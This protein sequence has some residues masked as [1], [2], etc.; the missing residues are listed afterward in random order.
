MVVKLVISVALDDGRAVITSDPSI[1]CVLLDWDLKG[2]EN[3][4]HTQ[5]EEL[6]KLLRGR[7]EKV[8]VFLVA[9]FL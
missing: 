7:N 4:V 5:Y 8:S 2:G 3:D 6:L 9:C 1:E